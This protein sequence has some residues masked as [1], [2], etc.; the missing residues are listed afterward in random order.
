MKPCGSAE[1]ANQDVKKKN[2]KHK[3][4]CVRVTEKHERW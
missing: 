1:P 4:K 2:I 3:K